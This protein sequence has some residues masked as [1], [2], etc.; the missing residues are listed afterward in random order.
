MP[1]LNFTPNAPVDDTSIPSGL[2]P[3][4]GDTYVGNS[5]CTAHLSNTVSG[6]VDG[7]ALG[8]HYTLSPGSGSGVVCICNS[9]G[10]SIADCD[11]GATG[12]NFTGSATPTPTLGGGAG[13]LNITTG[14]GGGSFY[15]NL[16]TV[17]GGVFSDFFGIFAVVAGIAVAVWV[18]GWITTR[19]KLGKRRKGNPYA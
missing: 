5:D 4:A 18:I 13:L 1:G 2:G 8:T 3:P 6:A 17:S 14:T 10:D 15:A 11:Y 12:Y 9:P 16:S 7:T 19:I